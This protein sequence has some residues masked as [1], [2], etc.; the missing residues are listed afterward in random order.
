MKTKTTSKERNI[1][2]GREEIILSIES[3][4]PPSYEDIQK[5]MGTD[6]D[7]TVIKRIGNNFGKHKFTAYVDIYDSIEAKNKIVTIPKKIR[8]K[9]EADKKAEEEASKKAEEEAAKKA[10][11]E[12]E[13]QEKS[14][15]EKE[16]K[17]ES[18]E[19]KDGD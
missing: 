1:F 4:T 16:G 9:M 2:F 17:V 14:P 5:E 15:M 12:P 13:S 19:N 7:L 8:K 10:E 6:K 18:E 11:E 3:E